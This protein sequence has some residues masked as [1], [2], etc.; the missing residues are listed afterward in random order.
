MTHSEN[1]KVRT[2]L[3]QSFKLWREAFRMANLILKAERPLDFHEK[4]SNERYYAFVPMIASKLF[5]D[6]FQ[7]AVFLIRAPESDQHVQLDMV[8]T[9]ISEVVKFNDEVEKQI[10]E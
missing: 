7:N 5:D 9:V 8:A 2:M 3:D 4:E 1:P 10:Q 6:Y